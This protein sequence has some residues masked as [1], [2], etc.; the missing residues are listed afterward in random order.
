M[1][2]LELSQFLRFLQLEEELADL[3]NYIESCDEKLAHDSETQQVRR[4]SYT[5]SSIGTDACSFTTTL[6]VNCFYAGCIR[7]WRLFLVIK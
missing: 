7:Q 2:F 3:N 1:C 5:I 6:C 4:G